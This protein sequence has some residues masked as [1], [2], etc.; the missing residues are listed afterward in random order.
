MIFVCFDF[1][2]GG[3]ALFFFACCFEVGIWLCYVLDV[4][5]LILL[6]GDKDT[7]THMGKWFCKVT[8]NFHQALERVDEQ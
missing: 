1:A 6:G 2:I 7:K 5:V 4:L 3:D 8:R